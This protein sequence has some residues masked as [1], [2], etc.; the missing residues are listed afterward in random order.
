MHPIALLRPFLSTSNISYQRL[1][2]V[3]A[4]L[5]L[6]SPTVN[7]ISH[8]FFLNYGISWTLQTFGTLFDFSKTLSSVFDNIRLH[9]FVH[10]NLKTFSFH[11]VLLKL[12][13]R[14][15]NCRKLTYYLHKC[16]NNIHVK[17]QV[18]YLNSQKTLFSIYKNLI[19][20]PIVF[21][22]KH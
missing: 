14:S 12:F 13:L 1:W 9:L 8:I 6:I 4:G 11:I 17:F 20:F 19:F 21:H 22:S 18:P 5:S 16:P 2:F 7:I 10:Y 3:I 15:E